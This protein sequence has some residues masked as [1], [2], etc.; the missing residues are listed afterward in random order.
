M[1]S[2]QNGERAPYLTTRQ[3]WTKA[4]PPA[5]RPVLGLYPFARYVRKHISPDPGKT[6]IEIGAFPGRL[7]GAFAKEFG[8][9]PTALDYRDDTNLMAQAF[10]R[11][12]VGGW[13]VVKADFLTWIPDRKYDVV[14][15]HG[16]VEHF[17][18]T[19][20]VVTKHL[21]LL[22]RGGLLVLSVPHLRY[23]QYWARRLLCTK[24]HMKEIL[25]THKRSI[26]RLDTLRRIIVGDLGQVEL[27]ARY[28]G[29]ASLWLST[30]RGHMRQPLVPIYH[31]L[32]LIGEAS[33]LV[34]L[35]CRFW[36]PTVLLVTKK[37]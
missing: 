27:E 24:E 11:I 10:L 18:D 29:W 4:M 1:N 14:L 16:F 23:Y 9:Q 20:L 12:G 8:F 3:Y 19:Q 13:R 32:G 30:H 21:E 25:A 17:A 26:M 6:V 28:L 37:P 15:S 31:A 36:S 22:K 5:E 7:L 34:G 35:S 2:D 33:R